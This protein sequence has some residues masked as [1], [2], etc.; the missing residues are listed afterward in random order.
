MPGGADLEPDSAVARRIIVI[1][2]ATPDP[3]IAGYLDD[4]HA[5]ARWAGAPCRNSARGRR[6]PRLGMLAPDEDALLLN[7]DTLPHR[8]CVAAWR[9]W[10]TR[11][12]TWRVTPLSNNGE[13]TSLPLRFQA[14]PLPSEDGW[15]RSIVWQRTHAGEPVD[16]PNGIGSACS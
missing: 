13:Y 12:P 7:A 1:D 5:A 4:L 16:L 14:N 15:R 9:A 6:E 8:T 11:G 3:R 2:D 10:R